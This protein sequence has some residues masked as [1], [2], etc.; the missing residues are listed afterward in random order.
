MGREND[1]PSERTRTQTQSVFAPLI[2]YRYVVA[3]KSYESARIT[4]SDGV[5]SSDSRVA[6]LVVAKYSLNSNAPVY[7]HP[8]DSS[9]AVL[10]PG[11]SSGA[12][13][14]TMIGL[15]FSVFLGGFLLFFCSSAGR[16]LLDDLIDG[17]AR[18]RAQARKFKNEKK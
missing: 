2:R 14:E 9:L 12:V 3:G 17:A 1:S 6:E 10:E 15:V 4:I 16:R 13:A 18:R 11:V 8:R 5:D 7:H